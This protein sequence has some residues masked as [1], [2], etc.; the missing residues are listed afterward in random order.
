[1]IPFISTNGRVNE[2][3][4]TKC[5]LNLISSLSE[6]KKGLNN[7]RPTQIR[8]WSGVRCVGEWNLDCAVVYSLCGL[9]QQCLHGC[10]DYAVVGVEG[11]EGTK[12]MSITWPPIWL[13]V[14]FMD[15]LDHRLYECSRVQQDAR[16]HVAWCSGLDLRLCL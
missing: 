14:P 5:S 6:K 4:A 10:R 3:I 15:V 1:M 2:E 8:G 11:R 9:G 12:F 7:G 16:H 13:H